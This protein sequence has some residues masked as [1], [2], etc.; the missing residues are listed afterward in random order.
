MADKEK[1][2]NPQENQPKFDWKNFQRERFTYRWQYYHEKYKRYFAYSDDFLYQEGL[3][4]DEDPV[5]CIEVSLYKSPKKPPYD[6]YIKYSNWQ[7]SLRV[8]F[9]KE[10]FEERAFEQGYQPQTKYSRIIVPPSTYRDILNFANDFELLHIRDLIVELIAIA[11]D[12]YIKDVV[13]WEQPE[14]Q[15]LITTAEKETAKA[16]QIIEQAGVDPKS[17]K[18]FEGQVPPELDH[19]KFVFNTGTIKLEHKWLAQEFVE[20]TMRHY[21]DMHYKDWKKELSRYPARFEENA[22]K[23][24]F[25]YRLA[26]S[27]YNLLTKAQFFKVGK[28]KPYPN[29]LML[30]IAKLI[31]FSLIPVGD[32]ADTDDVKIRHVRNWLKRTDLEPKI[33]YVELPADLERLKKY[34]ESHFIDMASANKRVDTISVAFFICTRFDIPDLLPDLLHIATCIKETNWLIG[35]QMTSNGSFNE[36]DVPEFKSLK[37]LM[38]GIKEN[39]KITSIKFTIK[40]EG[41]E[42]ELTQRLPLYLIEEAL[43]EYYQSDQVEFDTDTLPTTYEKKEEGS[44]QVKKESRFSLPH[45]RHMVR[46]VHSLYSYLKDHSGIEEGKILPGEP[47]YEIIAILFKECWVFYNKV[48][49]DRSVKEKIKQWHRLTETS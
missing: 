27:Y 47:Y 28:K 39:Q 36:P 37:A 6:F 7:L 43:R 41:D 42:H 9:F 35:H 24:K 45:E 40:G 32:W 44:I 22:H 10:V 12:I 46:L 3:L 33:T 18:N 16:I 1:T 29:Q 30:C 26:N 34:F 49:D 14:N 25:K 20:H 23:A 2:P 13:F 17:W 48:V 4:K 31:E 5:E 38:N 19:I 15:K 8:E 21:D 11:Q